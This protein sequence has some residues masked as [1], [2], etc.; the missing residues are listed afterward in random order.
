MSQFIFKKLRDPNN[1]YDT[2]DVI[3]KVEAITLP[4]LIEAFEDFLKAT[5]FVIN[6]KEHLDL[7]HDD[8]Y[9]GEY[10]EKKEDE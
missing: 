9:V 1:K 3:F 5:G 8:E 10:E 4:E 6:P 2:T 7:V